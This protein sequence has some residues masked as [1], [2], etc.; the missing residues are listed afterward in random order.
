MPTPN[1]SKVSFQETQKFNQWWIFIILGI[2]TILFVAGLIYQ[3]STGKLIGNVP[4]TNNEYLAALIL[5]G[6][7]DFLFIMGRLDT[8]IDSSG[9]CVR[10][11]PL[12]FVY[13]CYT[14]HTI[15]T[16]SVRNYDPISEYGGWGIRYSFKRGKALTTSGNMGIQ[17]VLKNGKKILIGTQRP[18]EV[19]IELNSF[20]NIDK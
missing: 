1:Y 15:E 11:F 13:T 2:T 8:K 16:A 19:K 4:M 9:I 3:E 5:L 20:I 17:I 12:G 14:W 6:I 18:D 10:F 7:I